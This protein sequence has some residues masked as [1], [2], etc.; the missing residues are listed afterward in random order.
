MMTFTGIFSG[1]LGMG[2]VALKAI[3]MDGHDEDT[4]FKV[5]I[6]MSNFMIGVTVVVS[7]VIY[8]H[9]GYIVPVLSAHVVGRRVG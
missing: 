1:F 2:S 7:A 3:G 9:R 5:S 4:F 6:T 8:F